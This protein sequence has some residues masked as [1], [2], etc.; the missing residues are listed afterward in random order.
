MTS[1]L[2]FYG[3]ALLIFSGS[4]TACRPA[5]KLVLVDRVVSPD[6]M[7]DAVLARDDGDATTPVGY[8]VYLMPHGAPL[9]PYDRYLFAAYDAD[10]LKIG[11]AEPS[12]VDITFLR[13]TIAHFRN[14][15]TD[16]RQSSEH[17]IEIRLRPLDPNTS[18]RTGI[19][20]GR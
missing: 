6:S 8:V 15:W 4:A 19:H 2:R 9:P 18:L 1:L 13:A 20:Y 3:L 12:V 16:N 5:P 17:R 10:S 11:W 14:L 7:F